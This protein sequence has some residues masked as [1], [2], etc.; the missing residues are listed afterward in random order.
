MGGGN[1]LGINDKTIKTDP[2]DRIDAFN[3]FYQDVSKLETIAD[4][5]RATPPNHARPSRRHTPNNLTGGIVPGNAN[6]SHRL[7]YFSRF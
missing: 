1:L 6:P 5:S 7:K 3:F 2:T 4:T